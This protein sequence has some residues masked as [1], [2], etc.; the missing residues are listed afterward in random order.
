[1]TNNTIDDLIFEHMEDEQKKDIY[2]YKGPVTING[3]TFNRIKGKYLF[4]PAIDSKDAYRHIRASIAQQNNCRYR[5][6]IIDISEISK[7]YEAV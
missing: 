5:D 6:V 2:A 7:V 3:K 4:S 1:M